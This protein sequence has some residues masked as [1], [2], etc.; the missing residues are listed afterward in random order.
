[1]TESVVRKNKKIKSKTFTIWE[2]NLRF[3]RK[4]VCWE[5]IS[6]NETK[7]SVMVA[8]FIENKLILIKKF[9]PAVDSYELVLPGGKVGKGD[10]LVKTAKR[11]LSEETKYY[12]KKLI[13]IG[14]FKILPAYLVGTTYA[15]IAQDLIKKKGLK[16]D[17]IES[18]KQ[19]KLTLAKA[20]QQIK[21]GKIRD[22]RTVAIILFISTFFQDLND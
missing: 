20:R 16:G 8:P 2:T 19:V 7:K 9:C 10:S 14:P 4:E 21:A 11:E 12:P 17:E 1:M 3:G 6:F 5:H 22:V 18:L 15:F 13:P